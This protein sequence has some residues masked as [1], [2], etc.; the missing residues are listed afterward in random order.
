M[1]KKTLRFFVTLLSLVAPIQTTALIAIP[2]AIIVVGI[3][4]SPVQATITCGGG[5]IVNGGTDNTGTTSEIDTTGS[6][7][8]VVFISWYVFDMGTPTFTDSKGN[9]WN[10]LNQYQSTNNFWATRLYWSVPTS[11]GT[12]HTIT[13]GGE[14]GTFTALGFLR[15]SGVKQVSPLD[16]QTGNNAVGADTNVQTGSIT[17][18]ENNQ[19]FV[20]VVSNSG[21][22]NQ[23]DSS[24]FLVDNIDYAAPPVG[25]GLAFKIQTTGGAENVTWSW[26]GSA[27]RTAA[28]A[29]FKM[30]GGSPPAGT[31]RSRL[32]T[33][34]GR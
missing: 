7:F 15:C 3:D 22:N 6:D 32:L 31:T 16:Q 1:L 11:V 27:N 9:M 21:S 33:G 24:F 28:M 8:L 12:G 20:T 19:L 13:G 34:V 30:E 18:T 4:I 17:P 26:T 14:A 5:T 10:A 25:A 2:T 23:P 29:T